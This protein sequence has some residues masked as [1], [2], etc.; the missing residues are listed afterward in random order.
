[1][2]GIHTS[3]LGAPTNGAITGC[4]GVIITALFFLTGIPLMAWVLMLTFGA[5]NHSVW[6]AVPAFGYSSSLIIVIA[7]GVLKALTGKIAVTK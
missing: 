1:M 6:Q 5:L 3:R 4:L 7:V 2:S